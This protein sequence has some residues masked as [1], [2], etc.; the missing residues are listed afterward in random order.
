MAAHHKLIPKGNYSITY[1]DGV[2]LQQLITH[3]KAM[4]LPVAPMNLHSLLLFKS[5]TLGGSL[6]DDTPPRAFVVPTPSP[7]ENPEALYSLIAQ[8]GKE[9]HCGPLKKN[10]VSPATHHSV[11]QATIRHEMVS[12]SMLR[13]FVKRVKE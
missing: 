11:L 1:F 6:S 12:N 7:I 2:L 10:D 3:T 8:N 9:R 5:P 13:R 4:E